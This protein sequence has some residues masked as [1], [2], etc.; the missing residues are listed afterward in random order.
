LWLVA[1]AAADTVV[2]EVRVALEQEPQQLILH[3][4]IQ[5]Q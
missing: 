4:L 3:Q 2:V 5:S 1:E